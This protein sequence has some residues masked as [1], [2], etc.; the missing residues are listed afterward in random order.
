[1]AIALY[2]GRHDSHDAHGQRRHLREAPSA[3]QTPIARND[4]SLDV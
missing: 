3:F 2:R 4:F 1:M